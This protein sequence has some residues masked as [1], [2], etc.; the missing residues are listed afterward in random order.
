MAL[1]QRS[2][3]GVESA[4]AL[5]GFITIRIQS[6]VQGN[7][8]RG[9]YGHDPS[10][11][12]LPP[13]L[14]SSSPSF[15]LPLTNVLPCLQIARAEGCCRVD[16][17]RHPMTF[18]SRRCPRMTTTISSFYLNILPCSLGIHA[19][20]QGTDILR[21]IAGT[22]ASEQSRGSAPSST[23]STAAAPLPSPAP[24]PIIIA[25]TTG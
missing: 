1:K 19:I 22:L 21:S 14:P 10:A 3:R 23:G 4:M 8:T 24:R 11:F 9:R 25:N 16:G 18:L 17:Y 20:M 5:G 6:I 12:H 2:N 7:S 13:P 15:V